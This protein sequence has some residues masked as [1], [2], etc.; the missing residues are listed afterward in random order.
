MCPHSAA[1]QLAGATCPS[2]TATNLMQAPGSVLPL[3]PM[4]PMFT[5]G[6]GKCFN[7]QKQK[8]TKS[9]KHTNKNT[10]TP[11][12][13]QTPIK[14]KHSQR[15]SYPITKYEHTQFEVMKNE[16]HSE[17]CNEPCCIYH[18]QYHDGGHAHLVPYTV[19]S[20]VG[21]PMARYVQG[22]R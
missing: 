17:I 7:T 10:H 16:T 22:I 12:L 15:S 21:Y 19:H 14:K 5:N 6:G 2:M 13:H 4:P 18:K 9:T 8:K 11:K 3:P 20:V 1:A